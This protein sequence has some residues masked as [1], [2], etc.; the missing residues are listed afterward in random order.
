MMPMVDSSVTKSERAGGD[1]FI[2]KYRHV[3]VR[4]RRLAVDRSALLNGI[5]P[6]LEPPADFGIK[7]AP[8]AVQQAQ[9]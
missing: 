8:V 9:R 5:R 2:P 7:G 3:G 6:R 4:A 1:H